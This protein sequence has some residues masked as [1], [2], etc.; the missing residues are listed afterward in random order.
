MLRF[1]KISDYHRFANLQSPEHPLI[2]L[3]DYT[4]IQYPTDVERIKWIQ[5]YYVVGLKRNVAYKFFYGQ[6]EYDF[7]EGLMTF[8]APNQVM[9]LANNPNLKK[10]PLGWLLL[11]HPDFLW[12]TTL[13]K[14]IKH[15]EFFGYAINEALFLSEKEEEMMIGILKSI[16]REYQSHIDKFSQKI[17]V[18]QLELLFNYAERFY[19]RQFITRKVNNHQILEKL[20][21]ALNIAF[22]KDFIL[23]HGLP[24]VKRVADSVGLSPNYLTSVLKQL[25]G[26]STKQYIHEK[27][28]EKAKE[29]LS[30]TYLSVS[31]IAYGLGFERP[32]SFTKLFK[33]KTE[34]SPLEF[35]K[36]FN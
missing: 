18:S 1:K 36:T 33:N 26:Q 22:G 35:R 28:I 16:E 14:Q 29:Q 23:D 12:N 9:S 20:E 13:A 27:L 10:K 25:T 21:D 34:M 24:T 11:I 8:V 2:S 7:D 5:D 19:E 31:E 32:A 17:V 6:Q 30:T 4:K 3:V 15:Y